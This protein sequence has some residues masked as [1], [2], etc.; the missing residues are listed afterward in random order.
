MTPAVGRSE[1]WSP[2][3]PQR[4]VRRP[5]LPHSPSISCRVRRS[6]TAA[7]ANN[8]WL[9]EM[10]DAVTK[11][12]WDNA[13]SGLAGHRPGARRLSN[14][15]SRDADLRPVG[16][17]ELPL[18][19]RAR[20]GRR[21]R[22][23]ARWATVARTGRRPRDRRRPWLQRLRVADSAAPRSYAVQARP[24][25]RAAGQDCRPPRR[26]DAA[27]RQRAAQTRSDPDRREAS[28]DR[29]PRS[30]RVRHEQMVEHPPLKSLWDDHSYD[31]GPQ[32]GMS[33]DLNFLHR[34]Q[35]LRDRLSEREQHP[36]RRQGR[37]GQRPRDALDPRRS[38]LQAA[39]RRRAQ[40]CSSPCACMH[41]ENAPCEQVC[42]VAA[43]CTT[44]KA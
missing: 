19:G 8:G 5:P 15:D 44:A 3:L 28:L 23:R 14:E 21:D 24:G 22:R 10:P 27:G 43:T 36:D 37:G 26:M 25:R 38:L 18:S 33:I 34:L 2:E 40:R 11:L 7:F 1:R 16:E 29:F 32:W 4:V 39:T 9:Q 13:A 30:P 35:R 12:T 17:L 42:P 20:T 31:D 6:S 41:C